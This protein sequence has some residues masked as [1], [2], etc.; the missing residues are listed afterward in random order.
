MHL[1]TS[2]VTVLGDDDVGNI[3]LD[4]SGWA[5]AWN[6]ISI[7]DMGGAFRTVERQ[8]MAFVKQEMAQIF[9]V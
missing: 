1:T 7:I 2:P 4:F 9:L 8:V 5:V 3:T 6:G